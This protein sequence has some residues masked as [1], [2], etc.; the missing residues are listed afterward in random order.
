MPD[1]PTYQSHVLDD[2]ALVAGRSEN[3]A[4]ATSS[5]KSPNKT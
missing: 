4:W 2:L 3:S 5:T 1:Q